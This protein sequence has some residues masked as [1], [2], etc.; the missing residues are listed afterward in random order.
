[1]GLPLGHQFMSD[2]KGNDAAQPDHPTE[3]IVE[4]DYAFGK[5][6]PSIRKVTPRQLCRL[7][8]LL[9]LL[10]HLA[11]AII[12]AGFAQASFIR[13]AFTLAP[14]QSVSAT[15]YLM[16]CFYRYGWGLWLLAAFVDGSIIVTLFFPS[17]LHKGKRIR[18]VTA[19]IAALVLGWTAV[20]LTT[21]A[22]LSPIRIVP[23][24]RPSMIL[25]VNVD[26][27]TIAASL[28]LM[29]SAVWLAVTIIAAVRSRRRTPSPAPGS[30]RDPS[31]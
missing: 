9:V 25:V 8:A 30:S 31:S 3:S 2:D 24:Q 6:P 23:A 15:T 26:Q 4:L 11:F 28:A 29:P 20:S 27:Y 5:P 10:I 12:I 22:L 13:T 1:M 18:P 19:V 21:L 16:L 7:F 14:G 17:E